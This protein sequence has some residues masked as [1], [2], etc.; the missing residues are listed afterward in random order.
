[1]ASSLRK[2][3]ISIVSLSDKMKVPP[4]KPKGDFWINIHYNFPHFPKNINSMLELKNYL[5]RF[6]ARILRIFNKI[7]LK[8][9]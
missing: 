7:E 3:R 9:I 6:S 5:I 1:M 8:S 2:K 4:N